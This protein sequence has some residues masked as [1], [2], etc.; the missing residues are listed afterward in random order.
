M[1]RLT[2]DGIAEPVTR[3]QILRRERGQRNI[4]F[5]CS[6]DHEQDWQPYPVDPCSCYMCDHTYIHTY[7]HINLNRMT[8]RAGTGCAVM[9]N[10]LH[11]KNICIHTW[12]RDYGALRHTGSQRKLYRPLIRQN[13]RLRQDIPP[14]APAS[15]NVNRPFSGFLCSKLVR[16]ETPE[17]YVYIEWKRAGSCEVYARSTTKLKVGSSLLLGTVQA[18]DSDTETVQG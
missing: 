8:S 17:T 3:D 11:I 2:R 9:C 18:V 14:Q 16:P 12:S 4:N 7:I 15:T 13:Q 1:I 6:A 5:P 10:M